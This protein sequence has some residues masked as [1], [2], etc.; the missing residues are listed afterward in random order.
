MSSLYV[1]ITKRFGV[2]GTDDDCACLPTAKS[3][4]EN[5]SKVAHEKK[6]MGIFLDI[7]E[8]YTRHL[9]V[10]AFQSLRTHSQ[11]N[12]SIVLGPGH[13]QDAVPMPRRSCS[14]QWS[15][16]ERIDWDAVDAGQHG[17]SSYKIRKGLSRK[18]QLAYHTQRYISKHPDSILRHVMPR[19]VILD[20]WSVWEDSAPNGAATSSNTRMQQHSSGLADVV[21]SLGTSGKHSDS[22][23]N[24]RHK[25]EQCLVEAKEVMAQ[26]EQEFQ[27]GTVSQAPMWILKG[28][29]VNKG[30]GIYI[31]HVYE[32]LVDICWS[33]SDIREW[34]VFE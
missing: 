18:A 10:Q 19:T 28:S 31:V 33:E 32:E 4:K 34:Y 15:E 30:A 7:N 9:I 14:F 17:A 1:H 16:Y 3:A 26:V 22:N 11:H 8:P 25:L 29:T 27:C 6:R 12:Y 24:P 2:L 20:T 13:G 23:C 5:G 21:T